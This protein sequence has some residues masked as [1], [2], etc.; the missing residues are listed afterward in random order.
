MSKHTV[1]VVI[2]VVLVVVL[3]GLSVHSYDNYRHQQDLKVQAAQ[4]AEAKQKAELHAKAVQQANQCVV[5]KQTYAQ[6][7][8]AVKAKTL[9]P[10]CSVTPLQ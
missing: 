6:L 4:Q 10:V 8:V 2:S 7:P 3:A 1:A 9:A 5:A